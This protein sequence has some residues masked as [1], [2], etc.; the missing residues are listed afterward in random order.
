MY[1]ARHA[2][3]T[4]GKKFGRLMAMAG[5]AGALV[6]SLAV[7]GSPGRGTQPEQRRK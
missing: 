5:L 4:G 6:L 7:P 2:K 1:R 3:K